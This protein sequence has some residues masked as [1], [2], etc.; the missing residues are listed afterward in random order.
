MSHRFGI[1]REWT[2]AEA[3]QWTKEDLIAASL[4]VLCFVGVAFGVPYAFLL[5]PGGFL[6]LALAA[7]LGGSSPR[8]ERSD[9]T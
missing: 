1:R 3:D 9:L 5:H 2:A 6:L 7:A 4:G 8:E